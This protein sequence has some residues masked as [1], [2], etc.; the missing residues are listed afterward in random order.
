M[1]SHIQQQQ[2]NVGLCVLWRIIKQA[3]EKECQGIGDKI[4]QR[5]EKEYEITFEQR[6]TGVTERTM[7]YIWETVLSKET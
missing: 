2:Q 1:Y 6:T 3:K 4:S 7:Q 5:T